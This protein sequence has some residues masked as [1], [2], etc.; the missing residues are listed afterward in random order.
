[1]RKGDCCEQS[2]QDRLRCAMATRTRERDPFEK[3]VCWGILTPRW[4]PQRP[5]H[6]YKTGAASPKSFRCRLHV[7]A[8]PN[9]PL[10]KAILLNQLHTHT[11]RLQTSNAPIQTSQVVTRPRASFHIPP[12]VVPPTRHVPEPRCH[13]LAAGQAHG[14]PRV[15][16][17]AVILEQ[18]AAPR[19]FQSRHHL[20]VRPSPPC[21]VSE[22]ITRQPRSTQI[23]RFRTFLS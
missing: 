1:M 12:R 7:S 6:H 13:T 15:S 18:Q 19:P 17:P 4:A 22:P 23:L 11:S 20:V 9:A 10:H 8:T 21:V 2:N 16:Q 3:K 5:G 14:Q